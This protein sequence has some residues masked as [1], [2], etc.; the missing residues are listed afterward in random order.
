MAGVVLAAQP[1][2]GR[3]VGQSVVSLVHSGDALV[4]PGVV[5]VKLKNKTLQIGTFIGAGGIL[6]S[7][8]Q[9]K[10]TVLRR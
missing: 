10:R 9:H 2:L 8:P 7:A 3:H 5:H 1:R 4:Y 6:P